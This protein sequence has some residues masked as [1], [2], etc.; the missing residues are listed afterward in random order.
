MAK[1]IYKSVGGHSS[2]LLLIRKG[3]LILVSKGYNFRRL[4]IMFSR[5]KKL[6][7]LELNKLLIRETFL[8]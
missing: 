1:Y 2:Y 4:F 5:G 6:E 7:E 3:S 8:K